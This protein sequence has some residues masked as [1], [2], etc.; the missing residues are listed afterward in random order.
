[1]V[2]RKTVARVV[3]KMVVRIFVRVGLRGTDMCDSRIA[4]AMKNNEIMKN[5]WR[6]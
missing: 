6:Y 2:V 1:M 4:F 5:C 3:E